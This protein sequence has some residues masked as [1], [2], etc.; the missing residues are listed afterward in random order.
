MEVAGSCLVTEFRF[1]LPDSL[2]SLLD[3]CFI[4]S[5]SNESYLNG[6]DVKL[7]FFLVS[8]TD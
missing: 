4:E 6:T 1:A 2:S 5:S 3:Y 8:F 7:I